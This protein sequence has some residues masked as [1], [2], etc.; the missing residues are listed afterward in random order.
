MH[1]LQAG[2][3]M[4]HTRTA[5]RHGLTSCMCR[6]FWCDYTNPRDQIRRDLVKHIALKMVSV[7][8]GNTDSAGRVLTQPACPDTQPPASARLQPSSDQL[9]A[10]LEQLQKVVLPRALAQ[11]RE[12]LTRQTLPRRQQPAEQQQAQQQHSTSKHHLPPA[13]ARE[14]EWLPEYAVT[15][16]DH[17]C[18]AYLIPVSHIAC[19]TSEV[20]GDSPYSTM[21]FEQK[22]AL[23]KPPVPAATAVS[24]SEL[25]NTTHSAKHP[26]QASTMQSAMELPPIASGQQQQAAAGVP[27]SAAMLQQDCAAAGQGLQDSTQQ[28]EQ[29]LTG[30]QSI[31]G[32]AKQSAVPVEQHSLTPA[33]CKPSQQHQPLHPLHCPAAVAAD[34][35]PHGLQWPAGSSLSSSLSKVEELLTA[36]QSRAQEAQAQAPQPGQ[37]QPL[38]QQGQQAQQQDQQQPGGGTDKLLVGAEPCRS[39]TILSHGAGW[40]LSPA[41]MGLQVSLDLSG[42]SFVCTRNVG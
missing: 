29:Q 3:L 26:A 9:S 16:F 14:Q 22:S 23:A 40:E 20:F 24:G 36:W 27:K 32:L 39:S 15:A 33:A 12:Q 34:A 41:V 10:L 7:A 1:T 31:L 30:D 17:E 25:D 42:P 5:C 8:L 21:P 18:D 6:C 13:G 37:Q 38:Q 28:L 35:A 2:H 11:H 4:C 19:Q